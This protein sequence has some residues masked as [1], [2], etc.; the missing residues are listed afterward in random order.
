M[1]NDRDPKDWEAAGAA[2]GLSERPMNPDF[3]GS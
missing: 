3:A 2:L 1:V